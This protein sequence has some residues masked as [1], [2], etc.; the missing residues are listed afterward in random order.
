MIREK[1]REFIDDF[2]EELKKVFDEIEEAHTIITRQPWVLWND[3]E[4][5]PAESSS[6]FQRLVE[7][8]KSFRK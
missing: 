7:Y 4:E 6:R 5:E 3:R 1:L 2:A 8:F